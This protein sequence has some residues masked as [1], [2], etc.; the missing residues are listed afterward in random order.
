ME[1][2]ATLKTLT[3]RT[4][5]PSVLCRVIKS[6]DIIYPNTGRCRSMRYLLV[7]AEVNIAT[8]LL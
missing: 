2:T 4:E 3:D 8:L 5:N 7:D 1:P 6:W